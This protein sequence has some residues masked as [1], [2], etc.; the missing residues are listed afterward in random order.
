MPR[1]N[2]EQSALHNVMSSY[3]ARFVKTG[4]PNAAEMSATMPAQWPLRTA[5]VERSLVVDRMFAVRDE[6]DRSA[7]ALWDR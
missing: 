2:T 7:C 3:W 6:L 1:F 4:D 5:T